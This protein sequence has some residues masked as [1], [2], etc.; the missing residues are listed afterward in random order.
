VTA[1]ES[2]ESITEAEFDRSPQAAAILSA[3]GIRIRE[4][5][6]RAGRSQR[7]LAD[8]LD[9][10]Q[11]AVSYW[12]AG[13]RDPGIADLLR[14]ADALD[15]PASSLL[16]VEHQGR[17]PYAADSGGGQWMFIAFMGRIE[18]TGYVTEITKHGQPAYRIEKPEKIWGGNPLA[19]VEHAASA[20]FSD[21]PV[22]EE[23]VRKAWEAGIR[24]AEKRR[25]QEAEWRRAD[26]QHAL[27]AGSGDDE[28]AGS[29]F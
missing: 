11:T 17:E 3:A 12:E 4:A 22:T 20:W 24:A 5:R 6:E 10:T 18:Y 25:Q 9:V 29:P 21:H 28:Y 7:Q 15:V 27:T 1:P 8:V 2:A 14:I 26:E 23:S 19:Y 13:K 16:P